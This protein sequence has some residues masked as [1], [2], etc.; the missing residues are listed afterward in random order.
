MNH[1]GQAIGWQMSDT[2]GR[3]IS[4]DV[5]RHPLVTQVGVVMAQAGYGSNDVIL[6]AV[7]GGRDSLALALALTAL[8][9]R[10][11]LGSLVIGHVNHHVR[12][13]ADQ[14]A[15]HVR[16][17]GKRI[18]IP[19]AESHLPLDVDRRPT[20][21]RA[22]RYEALAT[23]ARA[24][25]A[26]AVATGHHAQDQLETILLSLVRGAGPVG[27][28][29]MAC[30]RPLDDEIALIRPMLQCQR[31][32]AAA[33]CGLAGVDWCDDPGNESPDSLR[34]RLRQ[35]VLPVLESLRPGVSRRV[36]AG[37]ELQQAA[38][39][40]LR[41][42]VPVPEDGRW[43]RN[44]LSAVSS[45]LRRAAIYAAA[46]ELTDHVDRL[47]SAAMQSAAEAVGDEKMHQRRFE[48]GGNVLLTIQAEDVQI[49]QATS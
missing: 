26:K 49:T 45:P 5:R 7:S 10:G 36:A 38:A 44:A 23:M 33:L 2:D 14:E 35:D 6:A 25:K 47:S 34:G 15:A 37:A 20:Q 31:E 13:E 40:A 30:S 24:W 27:L 21:L 16:D 46:V 9:R 17:L 19:V 39:E 3:L 22:M 29:G 12:V 18:G 11:D 1:N 42:S 32:E 4:L 28:G 8:V 43:F 41:N 48:L